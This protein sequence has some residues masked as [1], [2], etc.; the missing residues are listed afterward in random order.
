MT[1]EMMTTI[2]NLAISLILGV[3][4]IAITV[5]TVVYSFMESTKE[6]RR[7]LSD[8]TRNANEVDP[9]MESD[10]Q[11]AIK[12]LSE[13]KRMNMI[14]LAI[15]FCDITA[16]VAYAA[17][18]VFNEISWLSI[19]SFVLLAI[20]AVLCVIALVA[21]LVQYFRRFKGL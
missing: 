11:F 9:V 12:R 8:K 3:L 10:L 19:T 1:T 20:L 15:V 2:D 13:L 4:G 18:L 5:F 6:R 14:V 21:Y 16:F 17:H 7:V